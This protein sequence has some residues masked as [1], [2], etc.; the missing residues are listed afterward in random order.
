MVKSVLDNCAN[1]AVVTSNSEDKGSSLFSSVVNSYNSAE[2][3]L[4]ISN[5]GWIKIYLKDA[6]SIRYLRFLLWDN[7]GSDGKRQPS[8]R[9]YTYR[10][11]IS[12]VDTPENE[13]TALYENT[14]NP[15]NGWQEFYFESGARMI[16]A[17]KIEFYHN[18]SHSS[19]HGAATQ[20][21]SIQAFEH[22]T[23][24]IA[25]LLYDDSVTTYA[26]LPNLGFMKNRVI[27]GDDQQKLSVLV[28]EAIL[29]R[30]R[31][32]LDSLVVSP[33][34]LP[35]SGVEQLKK[36]INSKAGNNDI[37]T[38]INIFNTSI[39]RPV[40]VYSQRLARGY[41]WYTIATITL[42]ACGVIGELVDSLCLWFGVEN[43]LSLQFVF[44]FFKS[45]FSVVQTSL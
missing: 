15:T 42:F 36:R 8:K 2:G 34:N 27:I 7:R 9:E 3:F 29:S 22:P 30:I 28:E 23:Q 12:E 16:K 1:V 26:P 35:H 14:L 45:M 37:E 21:V 40:Y 33:E 25:N 41:R 32:Y 10:L 31:D 5:P 43:P 18:T 24:I 4:Q 6:Q 39:L 19:S 20:L 44:Q 11:L 17:I 13:W 38:Q